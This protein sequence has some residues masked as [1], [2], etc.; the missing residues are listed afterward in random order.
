[1]LK[2]FETIATTDFAVFMLGLVG[3]PFY[4][5]IYELIRNCNPKYFSITCVI[6]TYIA[7]AVFVN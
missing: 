7:I 5:K 2:I 4:G 1:M 3:I 6:I